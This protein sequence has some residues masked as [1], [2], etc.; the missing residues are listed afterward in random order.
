MHPIDHELEESDAAT[1]A[2][3]PA[4]LPRLRAGR[5]L[6]PVDDF[7][8]SPERLAHAATHDD[9][10]GLPNRAYTLRRLQAALDLVAGTGDRLTLFFVDLDHFK[11]V[12]DTLG[13]AAGDV[14][15]TRFANRLRRAAEPDDIVGRLG[16]DEFVVVTRHPAGRPSALGDRLMAS[17]TEPIPVLDRTLRMTS[18]V[19][20]ATSEAHER[21]PDRLLQAADTALFEAKRLGRGRVEAFTDD[22]RRRVVERVELESELRIALDVGQ[23]H[24][25]YQPQV[26]LRTGQVVGAEALARWLHPTRGSVPPSVFVPVAEEAG[27][28]RALGGWVL[29]SACSQLAVWQRTGSGPRH[30]TINVSALQLDDEG[31]ADDVADALGRHGLDA[32]GLCIEL[33]ESALMGRERGTRTLEAIRGLGCYVGIDDFGTGHSSLARLRE[34]PVEVLKI[35]RSFVDGL[36]TDPSDSAIVASIMSMAFAMG[37]H[38]IAEGVE[39]DRQALALSRL[40]CQ[41]AQGYLFSRPVSAADLGD[42]V[43]RRL[44]RPPAPDLAGAGMTE[45][46]APRT[47]RR[48]HR[49]FVH[50]FLHQIGFEVDP[51]DPVDPVERPLGEPS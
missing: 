5:S 29:R 19:G 10:T 33:T 47:T 44:W 28:V 8:R 11:L 25:E 45:A 9:L 12:N 36:G 23:L 22:L 38:V 32:R 49:R 26:D 18:S 4:P 13:H 17:M 27:M 14:L 1:A 30:V 51:G 39:H 48:G 43:G 50:E 35:D 46:N 34:L 2:R 7:Y 6:D 15:L 37:L 41:F 20:C 42:Q 31:F 40:G 3:G 24:L 16:G 21:V